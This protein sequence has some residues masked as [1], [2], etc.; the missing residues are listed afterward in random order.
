MMIF[1][2]Y[3]S[4]PEGKSPVLQIGMFSDST[5]A[6]DRPQ[7]KGCQGTGKESASWGTGIRIKLQPQVTWLQRAIGWTT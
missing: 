2:S 6:R 5:A 7:Q 1:H 3:V 4:L